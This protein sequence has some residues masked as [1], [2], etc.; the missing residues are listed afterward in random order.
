MGLIA[1]AP[2]LGFPNRSAMRVT[3][4]LVEQEAAPRFTGQ[5]CSQVACP[6]PSYLTLV[7]QASPPVRVSM[8]CTMAQ[9][10]GFGS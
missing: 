9:C 10:I 2:H 5:V 4:T 8:L 1:T 7:V 6:W 3:I